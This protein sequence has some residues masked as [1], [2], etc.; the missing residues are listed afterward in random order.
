MPAT[1][2]ERAGPTAQGVE[3]AAAG[4][5]GMLAGR[6]DTAVA[7]GIAAHR[8]VGIGSWVDT[9]LIHDI[10]ISCEPLPLARSKTYRCCSWAL[11]SQCQARSRLEA[12]RCIA[13]AGYT[14]SV[15]A[16]AA[17]VESGRARSTVVE[18]CRCSSTWM[19][20]GKGVVGEVEMF[21]RSAWR[22]GRAV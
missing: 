11:L 5:A 19:G 14:C 18:P 16:A 3:A 2:A 8:V 15:L 6:P 4:A 7:L 1:A 12:R 10:T 13:A 22:R 21:S 17:A 9:R 20:R